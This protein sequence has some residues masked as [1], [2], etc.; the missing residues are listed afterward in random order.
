MQALK[1]IA[2][3]SLPEMRVF[4]KKQ[5]IVKVV[6]ATIS[7]I[8]LALTPKEDTA[9]FIALNAVVCALTLLSGTRTRVVTA[10]PP[11]LLI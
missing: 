3:F 5:A 1:K 7:I 10:T 4:Y 2:G 8:T 9:T 6:M 11:H